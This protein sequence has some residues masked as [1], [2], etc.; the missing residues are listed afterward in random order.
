MEISAA[1]QK[2]LSSMAGSKEYNAAQWVAYRSMFD[3][4][5]ALGP[6]LP[7][8]PDQPES[9]KLLHISAFIHITNFLD[10]HVSDMWAWSKPYNATAVQEVFRGIVGMDQ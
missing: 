10:S 2:W 1:E 4:L 5:I 7:E 6:V 9:S 3:A 8:R